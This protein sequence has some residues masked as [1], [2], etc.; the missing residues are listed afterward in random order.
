MKTTLYYFTGTGN[1]LKIARD[2]ASLLDDAEVLSI[3]RLLTEMQAAGEKGKIRPKAEQVGFAF[4]V[5]A[6]GVPRIVI[7]FLR[8]LDLSQTQYVFALVTCGGGPGGTLTKFAHHLKKQGIILKAGFSIKMPDNY[9]LWMSGPDSEKQKQICTVAKKR[10]TE[11]AEIIKQNSSRPLEK[12]GPLYNLMGNVV[13]K[14]FAT[15]AHEQD[16]F[17]RALDRCNACGICQ[18]ICPTA[19]ISLVN[20]KPVWQRNCEQ[21]LACLQWCPTEAIQYR[22][23]TE[24]RRRYHHPGVTLKDLF[25]R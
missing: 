18:R 6:W 3:P 1:S 8:H 12:N 9:I 11:I 13:H 15:H 10:L 17:F 16:K 2:L 5:Y 25:L 14:L 7:N 22:K 21:C 19:N 24:K 23:R 4:P 20:G